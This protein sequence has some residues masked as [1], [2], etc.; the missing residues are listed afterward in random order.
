M[1]AK[2]IILHL[3]IVIKREKYIVA[4]LSFNKEK[5]ELSYHWHHAIDS[6]KKHLFC[7]S[8][9]HINRQD[10]LT[11]HKK[12]IHITDGKKSSEDVFYSDGTL[13]SNPP[14][15]TPLFVD[16]VY[17]Q[18]PASLIC[19]AKDLKHKQGRFVRI[20]ERKEVQNFSLVCLLVP[21]V[22]GSARALCGCQFLNIPEGFIRS[23]VLIDLWD[24]RDGLVPIRGIWDQWEILVFAT[25]YTRRIDSPISLEIGSNFRMPDYKRPDAALTNLLLQT[26][27]LQLKE[28]LIELFSTRLR[29]LLHFGKIT[30]Y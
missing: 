28:A 24:P 29:Q 10:H 16:S 6:P 7:I 2:P 5:E 19:G 9:E 27:P 11:F 15:L 23:P 14:M 18:E 12:N 21:S 4:S 26:K 8:G 25:S 1:S 30:A 3:E 13:L 20:L 17:L 22:I